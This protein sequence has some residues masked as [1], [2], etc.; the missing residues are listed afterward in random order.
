MPSRLRILV[1]MSLLLIGWCAIWPH[2]VF[3]I[4]EGAQAKEYAKWCSS[5]GGT[6]NNRGGLGCT[7]P[8]RSSSLGGTS[9][10]Q[11]AVLGLAGQFGFA[12]GTAIRE[13]MDAAERQREMERM[14]AEWRAAQEK[15]LRDAE[16]ERLDKEREQKHQALLSKLKGGF[17][18]KELGLKKMGPG[19]LELKA[20]TALFGRPANPTGVM[21]LDDPGIDAAIKIPEPPATVEGV[22][23]QPGQV[24]AVK[25]AWDDYL[26]AVQRSNQA[27]ARLKQAEADQKLVE[28]VRQEAEK[29]HREQQQKVAII[30]PDQP[31]VRKEE[32][33]KLAQAEKLF[34]EAI[35]LDEK[36]A[37][38]LER[39]KEDAETAQKELADR[40]AQK[41]KA[42]SAAKK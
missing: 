27:K 4:G 29:R 38:E 21:P 17:G 35:E 12:L 30:P 33:D 32:D 40:G 41:N 19:T 28:Q 23:D 18:S 6:L 37:T 31:E 5:I 24:E 26:A 13:S 10:N 1:V 34:N 16:L 8:S 20:G 36:A 9:S 11:Q 25:Q 15:A 42:M 22:P 39:A 7:P 14:E 2:T 3:A